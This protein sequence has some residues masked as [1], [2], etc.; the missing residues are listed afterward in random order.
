MSKQAEVK[1]GENDNV[2]KAW[3][4]KR[5]KH[6]DGHGLLYMSRQGSP[7]PIDEIKCEECN[8]RGYSYEEIKRES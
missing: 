6:C 8:G 3:R 4:K 5:C 2:I 7:Y 1:T